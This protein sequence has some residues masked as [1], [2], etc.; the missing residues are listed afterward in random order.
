MTN[1][2]NIQGQLARWLE[3]RSQYDMIKQRRPGAKHQNADS[4]SRIPHTIKSC[5]DNRPN[6]RYMPFHVEDVPIVLI[7]LGNNGKQ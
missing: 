1:F 7:E 4:L 5:K 6:F 3:E 2:K